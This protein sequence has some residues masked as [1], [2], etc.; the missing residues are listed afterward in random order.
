MKIDETEIVF[1]NQIPTILYRCGETYFIYN[2][3]D[4][5]LPLRMIDREKAWDYL[6]IP[7]SMRQLIRG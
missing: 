7:E 2:Q 6:N 1:E 4:L 3:T 5:E